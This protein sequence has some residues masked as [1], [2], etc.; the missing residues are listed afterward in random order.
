M[1]MIPYKDDDTSAKAVDVAAKEIEKTDS[2][3]GENIKNGKEA[4]LPVGLD[5]SPGY[6]KMPPYNRV[7][8]TSPT[9]EPM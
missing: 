1:R 7:R 6:P 3:T 9:M 8:C 4:N 5:L 2:D